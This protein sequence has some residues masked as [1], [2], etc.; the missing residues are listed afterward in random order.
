MS[1]ICKTAPGSP[2]N[3]SAIHPADMPASAIRASDDVIATY[4][5]PMNIE[6][7]KMKAD[8]GSTSVN[9]RT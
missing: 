5:I 3:I 6:N 2:A 9:I 4:G 8:R 1:A 7:I